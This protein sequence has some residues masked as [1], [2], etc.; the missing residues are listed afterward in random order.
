MRTLLPLFLLLTACE[1]GR[2]ESYTLTISQEVAD[3]YNANL[4]GLVRVE[5]VTPLAWVICDDPVPETVELYVDGGFGCVS[6]EERD[7]EVTK[8]AWIEAMPTSWDSGV[9]CQTDPQGER[10][11]FV[12]AAIVTGTEELFT[13]TL[14]EEVDPAW[15]QASATGSWARDASPCGG[16]LALSFDI[17]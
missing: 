6:E 16:Q 10:R 1:S 13:T 12:P 7:T 4:P 3:G 2:S 15:P 11:G 5:G 9:L 17:Q 8:T 14:A